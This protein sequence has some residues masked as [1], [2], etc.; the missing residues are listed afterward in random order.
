MHDDLLEVV[1]LLLPLE[2]GLRLLVVAEVLEE[3]EHGQVLEVGLLKE[4]EKSKSS[5]EYSSGATNMHLHQIIAGS[6]EGSIGP[7]S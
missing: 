1:I 2:K 3:D 5:V 4:W 6:R 7:T